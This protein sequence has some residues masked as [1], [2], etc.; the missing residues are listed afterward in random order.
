MAVLACRP[1]KYH[2]LAHICTDASFMHGMGRPRPRT[3]VTCPSFALPRQ[4]ACICPAYIYVRA[5]F[6]IDLDRLEDER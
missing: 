3:D 2:P 5:F 4:L 6:C 1:G